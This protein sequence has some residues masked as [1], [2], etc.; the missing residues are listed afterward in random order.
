[1]S[2]APTVISKGQLLGQGITPPAHETATKPQIDVP[3]LQDDISALKQQLAN[4]L[5]GMSAL[6]Q[7]LA[8]GLSRMDELGETRLLEARQ[9]AQQQV[10]RRSMV[11]PTDTSSAFDAGRVKAAGDW[12][13]LW[14][15]FALPAHC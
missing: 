2:R 11:D 7:Q 1:M 5:I 8:D 4:G 14:R 12:L 15:C 13:G 10:R 9:S 3:G 6:Q